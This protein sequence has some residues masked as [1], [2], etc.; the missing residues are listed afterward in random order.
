MV[1]SQGDAVSAT[2]HNV[3]PVSGL[4]SVMILGTWD[5]QVTVTMHKFN[6]TTKNLT[7]GI[8]YPPAFLPFDYRAYRFNSHCTGRVREHT[9]LHFYH[10]PERV[11]SRQIAANPRKKPD[12]SVPVAPHS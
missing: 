9:S 12:F 7:I 2:Q 11:S 8:I 6:C 10:L 4:V 1:A 3:T 5:A